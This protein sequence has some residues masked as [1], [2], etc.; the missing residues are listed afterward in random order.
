M[1][2]PLWHIILLGI[3]VA[4]MYTKRVPE[5][6]PAVGQG[7]GMLLVPAAGSVHDCCSACPFFFF[8]FF[9]CPFV[10]ALEVG[11]AVLPGYTLAPS[12]AGR[13]NHHWCNACVCQALPAMTLCLGPFCSWAVAVC[14][15]YDP[16]VLVCC[17]R[18]CVLMVGAL[19]DE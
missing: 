5:A 10:R 9:A 14:Q 7:R 15:G 8:F 18:S 3:C 19:E 2:L 11:P 1:T 17:G 12:A 16:P 13:D 6:P 4:C